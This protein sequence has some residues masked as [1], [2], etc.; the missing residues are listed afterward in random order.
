[1]L[2]KIKPHYIGFL[3]LASILAFSMMPVKNVAN[4]FHTKEELLYF[5]EY[6]IMPPV[7][8]SI[9]FPTA[10][11]CS[12]CHGKDAQGYAMIDSEGND[13]NV[14]DDWQTSMMAN[15]AKDP[16]WRAKVSHEVL[17][18]PSHQGEIE[19]KCTSCHAPQGHYTSKLR[20][21]GL[22][23]IEDLLIDTVGLDGVSCMSCHAM[24]D[25]L[26][27]DLN[28]GLIEYDTNRVAFGPYEMPFSQPMQSF[29]GFLPVYSKHIH[30]AGMCASCHTLVNKTVDL[31]GNETG[32]TLIEQ[33]TYHEWLNSIYADEKAGQT[34]QNCHMPQITDSI[35]ISSNYLFLSGRSPYGLHELVG[36]NTFMLKLMKEHKEELGINATD[37][38]FD[39]T[40]AK[41]YAMLQQKSVDLVLNHD[42]ITLDTAYFSLEILNKA[43]HK[44]PSGYPSRRAVVE[45]LVTSETGDTLFQSGML[46]E[47]YEAV[48]IDPQFEPHYNVIRS[49]EEVQIYE[50][51]VGNVNNEF[52]TLLERGA[53]ALKDNRLPPIGFT[54]THQVYDTTLIAGRA[55]NDPNF[56]KFNGFE[57]SGKDKISYHFPID[58]YVGNVNVSARI[59]YQS[60][61]PRWLAPMLAEDTPEINTF[62]EM[63][64]NAD[65]SPVLVNEANL[66]DIF[67]ET[68]VSTNQVVH[69]SNTKISPNPSLDGWFTIELNQ[70]EQVQRVVIFNNNGQLISTTNQTHFNIETSGFYYVKIET[71]KGIY[72]HKVAVW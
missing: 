1:M 37:E 25:S 48:G 5:Q 7:D 54:T 27:G 45:F 72:T 11:H 67:I 68:M 24:K 20:G 60:L 38:M 62:R 15:S 66:E 2:K 6:R 53:V 63:Y 46:D 71:D 64:N 39:E 32:E 16:F 41:T 29:V 35:V 57:G 55:L 56:N 58:G 40:I 9:L 42:S 43:G 19:N 33:A 4:H 3:I 61:P 21:H 8:S 69:Q 70:D 59:W 10:S 18:N 44:F 51:V 31:D 34:C 17:Y 22:Y 14:H 65:Q 30:D 12:G 36:G 52:S 49:E 47:N 23:T 50:V 26:L 28:S 13:V